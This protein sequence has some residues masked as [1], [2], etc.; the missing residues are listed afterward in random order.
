MFNLTQALGGRRK[1][2]DWAEKNVSGKVTSGNVAKQTEILTV[3]AE[4]SSQS[5]AGRS[6]FLDA[7]S[8]FKSS[9]HPWAWLWFLFP[10]TWPSAIHLQHHQHI[11]K[12][13]LLF[14][15]VV[16]TVCRALCRYSPPHPH[17]TLLVFS[18]LLHGKSLVPMSPKEIVL[19]YLA[20]TEGCCRRAGVRQGVTD[21]DLNWEDLG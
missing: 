14:L 8:C 4:L 19:L 9:S 2:Q 18:C 21:S 3:A 1:E 15:V 11:R 7:V 10:A 13:T 6:P 17:N 5:W 20:S 16:P 12:E